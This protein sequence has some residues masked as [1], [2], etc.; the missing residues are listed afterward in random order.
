MRLSIRVLIARL[1]STQKFD[2]KKVVVY[3]DSQLVVNQITRVYTAKDVKMTT[4]L[5]QVKKEISEFTNFSI[6]QLF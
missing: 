2:A 4:Y 6:K 1:R 3:N 5:G